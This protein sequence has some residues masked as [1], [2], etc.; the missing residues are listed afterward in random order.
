MQGRNDAGEGGILEAE[1]IRVAIFIECRHILSK[2]GEQQQA[3][4]RLWIIYSD[5]YNTGQL[6]L[7][8]RLT[9]IAVE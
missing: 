6:P 7:P 5:R 9:S 3:S 2:G 8:I 4:S 1:R